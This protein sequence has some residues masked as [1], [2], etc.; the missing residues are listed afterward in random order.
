VPERLDRVTIALPSGDVT[1]SWNTRQA[2]MGRL[3]D[4]EERN[5]IRS[6]FHNVGASRPAQFSPRQRVTLQRVLVDWFAEGM[7]AELDELLTALSDEVAD[8]D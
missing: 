4:A 2:L 8:A 5:L 1:I 6:Y 7:P 3:Q